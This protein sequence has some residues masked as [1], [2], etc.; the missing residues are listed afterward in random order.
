MTYQ[1]KRERLRQHLRKASR[2][3][4][5][6]WRATSVFRDQLDRIINLADYEVD[7]RKVFQVLCDIADAENSSDETVERHLDKLVW[8]PKSARSRRMW[9]RD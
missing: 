1:E 2:S 5:N 9:I 7:E 3:M 6:M 8:Q 4:R